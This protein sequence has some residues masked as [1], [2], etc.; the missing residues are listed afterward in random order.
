MQ[1]YLVS[2]SGY[3]LKGVSG[4]GVSFTNQLSM[5]HSFT[6]MPIALFQ[7]VKEQ[8]ETNLQCELEMKFV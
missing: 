8:V 6:K 7:K 2:S 1:V 4:N 3:F 5:A